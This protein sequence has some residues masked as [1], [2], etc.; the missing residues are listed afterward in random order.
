MA[1]PALKEILEMTPTAEAAAWWAK[2]WWDAATE[3][4]RAAML[5]LV[6]ALEDRTANPAQLALPVIDRNDLLYITD[7]SQR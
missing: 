4:E 6:D 3:L 1:R 7:Q 5:A 2:R